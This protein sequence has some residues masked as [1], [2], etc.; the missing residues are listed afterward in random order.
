MRI[1]LPLDVRKNFV[2]EL[3]PIFNE[4]KDYLIKYN[5][6]FNV[7]IEQDIVDNFL[8]DDENIHYYFRTVEKVVNDYNIEFVVKEKKNFFERIFFKDKILFK[9]P[10]LR[11][12]LISEVLKK[13]EGGGCCIEI[14]FNPYLKFPSKFVSIVKKMKDEDFCE[15]F[16]YKSKQILRVKSIDQI[17]NI[18]KIIDMGIDI[19]INKYSE[20][21]DKTKSSKP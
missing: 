4:L 13:H 19:Y 15:K 7:V 1:G 14:I 21:M 12:K 9:T 18:K 10:F 6:N 3:N 11:M 8:N 2:K 20:N 16:P 5:N 17:K